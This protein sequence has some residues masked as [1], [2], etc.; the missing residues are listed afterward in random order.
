MI[1]LLSLFISAVLFPLFYSS[2]EDNSLRDYS[3][4]NIKSVWFEKEDWRLTYPVIAL[5]SD[6]QLTLHFDVVEGDYGSL[7]YK[8]IHCDRDWYNSDLFNSDYLEGFEENRIS[9]YDASFNTTVSYTHYSLRLPNEDVQFKISGNYLIV[10]YASGEED[11]PLLTRRFYVHENA[12]TASVIFRRPMT[13]GTSESHQQPEITIST[14]SLR[15]NDPYREV[16]ISVLQNGRPDRAKMSLRPDFVGNG[17]LEYHSL[18]DRTLFT[19]GNEFR[20]FDIKTIRQKRQNVRSIEYLT[21]KYHVFLL[22]SEDREYKQYFHEE[23]FNGKYWIAMEESDTP[24]RDADYVYVYFT[25]PVATELQG[26]SLYVAG[27]FTDW[28]YGPLNRMSYNLS[29]GWY[30]ATLLLKQGWYNYEFVFV[31]KGSDKPGEA[32]FEGNHYETEN[33][34]LILTY[35]RDPAQRYDRLT[36]VTVANTTG[37]KQ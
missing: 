22:P 30:E 18:S 9:S 3:S 28:S 12:T 11:R 31:P 2:G 35:F 29:R 16:T 21:G 37:K 6:K 36:G 1:K 34:Y 19:G 8:I 23:D 15:I 20:F 24:D 33:D 13:P 10:I 32:H 5:Y 25:L 7:S 26:G 14:G 17:R 4:E 27:A